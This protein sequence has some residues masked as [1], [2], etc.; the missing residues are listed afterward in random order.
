MTGSTRHNERAVSE[1]ARSG[2]ADGPGAG[3]R[4]LDPVR[5]TWCDSPQVERIGEWGPQLLTEQ[6][7]CLA[8]RSP[9]QWIR[10]R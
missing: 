6:Y 9:F 5:C 10:R 1:A 4:G 8:C 2:T 3:A 7:I